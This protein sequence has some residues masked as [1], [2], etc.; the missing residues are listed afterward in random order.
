M[1]IK[2]KNNRTLIHRSFIRTVSFIHYCI[3]VRTLKGYFNDWPSGLKKPLLL[4]EYFEKAN[5]NQDIKDFINTY[6][7]F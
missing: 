5:L 2:T 3:Y 6:K 4:K 7:N 1:I